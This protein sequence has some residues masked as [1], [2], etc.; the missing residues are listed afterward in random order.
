MLDTHFVSSADDFLLQP[1]CEILFQSKAPT[2][3]MVDYLSQWTVSLWGW[4]DV[5]G[6]PVT[7]ISAL[8]SYL[9]RGETPYPQPWSQ[10]GRCW[11]VSFSHMTIPGPWTWQTPSP[12]LADLQCSLT[13]TYLKMQLYT[14][15]FGSFWW[16]GWMLGTH[17]S[18]LEIPSGSQKRECDRG[19]KTNGRR[20]RASM[21]EHVLFGCIS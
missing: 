1:S 16:G 19:R 5:P 15:C 6:V 17:I 11:N 14:C 4:Q 18:H 7:I 13:V 9:G 12:S 8:Q 3:H 2:M 20:A 10:D 21:R